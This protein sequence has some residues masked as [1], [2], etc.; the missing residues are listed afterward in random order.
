M[1]NGA[2]QLIKP[3]ISSKVVSVTRKLLVTDGSLAPLVEVSAFLSDERILS[4]VRLGWH[5]FCRGASFLDILVLVV[6]TDDG[7]FLAGTN[8]LFDVRLVVDREDEA[9]GC[10]DMI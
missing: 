8:T 10:F 4:S 5:D 6:A 3:V 9:L 1:A 2:I 7:F